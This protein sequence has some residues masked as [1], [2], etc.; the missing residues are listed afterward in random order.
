MV[1]T[2]TSLFV[3]VLLASSVSASVSAQ[4][5]MENME[6]RAK[7]ENMESTT[8]VNETGLESAEDFEALYEQMR[9]QVRQLQGAERDLSA[10]G[11]VEKLRGRSATGENHALF[12]QVSQ[13]KYTICTA[14]EQTKR[15][16]TF[17]WYMTGNENGWGYPVRGWYMSNGKNLTIEDYTYTKMATKLGC[18]KYPNCCYS[19]VE[20]Q[21]KEIC[22]YLA[23][24]YTSPLY[25]ETKQKCGR[26]AWCGSSCG[27]HCTVPW[28][29]DD[30][31]DPT[32]ATGTVKWTRKESYCC[33]G[34]NWCCTPYETAH[35]T[36]KHRDLGGYLRKKL[37]CPLDAQEDATRWT[38]N[39]HR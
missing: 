11:L 23:G 3:M 19:K 34:W 30:P 4:A 31:N 33:T 9:D 18:S 36:K 7:M 38:H 1:P 27:W 15:M 13:G 10:T 28:P 21:K 14:E 37:G 24:E 35:W 12:A 20:E 16:C 32:N 29:V 5:K 26:Y 8:R 17:L 25:Y 2:M 22:D 39:K 6:N